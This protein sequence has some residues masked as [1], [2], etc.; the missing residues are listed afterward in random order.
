MRTPRRSVPSTRR[1]ERGVALVFVTF[2]IAALLVAIS[3]AL[4]T[5]SA[6]SRA[7]ANY[8]GASQIHFVAESGISHALQ[9][10]NATGTTHFQNQIVADWPNRF[11]TDAKTIPGMS[12][13]SYTVTVQQN[14][15]NPSQRGR[16]ISTATGPDNY[17]NTVV[18]EV[19]RTN[20]LSTAPGAVY[21]ATDA[22]VTT[23]FNGNNF[24]IDGND[25][26]YNGG[27][28]PGDPVPGLSTRNQSNTASV[29]A[30][31]SGP[32]MGNI[33]G[34]G[35]QASPVVPSVMTS[36]W[37]PSINQ[38]N[39]YIS[40]LLALGYVSV[41]TGNITGNQTLGTISPAAPQLSYSAGSVVVKGAGTV[42]G[43]GVWIIDGDL[44]IQGTIDF[45]GLIIVRGQTLVSKD[46]GVSVTGNATVYG[47]LWS[48]DVKFSAG[49]SSIVYYST[50]A[51][52][53]ANQVAG[54]QAL[55]T[56]VS[57]DALADCAAVPAGS[58][59]CPS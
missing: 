13:F 10:I 45:A 5:G 11:G 2:A 25:H 1:S 23:D 34:L 54:G 22:A 17:R 15:A 8:K 32:Q 53:L 35:F 33:T 58:S 49:G 37:A 24:V 6:N 27:M 28:G 7:T 20:N 50:N 56:T 26:D 52:A 29:I 18:A 19:E 3:G 16:I 44:E 55:P 51:L 47:S 59:G 21:L 57:V 31:L 38:M 12:G 30:D 42:E 48:Q 4:V 40:D 36:A 9:N 39:Q 41:G 43:A 14:A 46:P